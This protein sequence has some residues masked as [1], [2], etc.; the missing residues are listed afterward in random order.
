MERLNIK[1]TL[2]AYPKLS[3]SLLSNYVTKDDLSSQLSSYVTEAPVNQ[4]VYARQNEQWVELNNDTLYNTVKLYVG[5]SSLDT[6][7]SD[8]DISSFSYVLLNN[9]I[10]TYS[11]SYTQH[12]QQYYWIVTSRQILSVELNNQQ[13]E[14]YTQPN[15][16][17][18][19]DS[20]SLYCYRM[21]QQE[22]LQQYTY[23]ITYSAQ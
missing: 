23:T 4:G 15:N 3:P 7:T 22:A 18:D 6:L 21:P 19:A 14:F 13:I 8:A 9:N 5:E 11:V 10:Q 2:T 1:T 20:T 16:I 17:T 12:V